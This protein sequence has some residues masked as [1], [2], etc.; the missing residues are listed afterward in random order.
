MWN[1]L[2][3]CSL[4][5]RGRGRYSLSSAQFPHTWGGGKHCIPGMIFRQEWANKTFFSTTRETENGAECERISQV[6]QRWKNRRQCRLSFPRIF[7]C[8]FRFLNVVAWR[9]SLSLVQGE[10]DTYFRLECIW[11]QPWPDRE[12]LDSAFARRSQES[13]RQIWS[14]SF[15]WLL[16][17]SCCEDFTRC[18]RMVKKDSWHFW[19]CQQA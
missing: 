16:E 17:L 6:C 8:L 1:K 4:S 10:L 19:L 14:I 11:M 5:S 12:L 15:G 13:A 3:S 2:T 7:R 18:I 9:Y